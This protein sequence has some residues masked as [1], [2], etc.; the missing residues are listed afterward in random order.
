M[1]REKIMLTPDQI[2]ALVNQK[3]D[4]DWLATEISRAKLVGIDI[5]D[6]ETRF[7]KMKQLRLKM[8]KEYGNTDI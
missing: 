1:A 4:L 3:D 6:L 7:N 5:T 8:L 2:N